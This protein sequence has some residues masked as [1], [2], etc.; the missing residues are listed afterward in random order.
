MPLKSANLSVQTT[1]LMATY[2]KAHVSGGAASVLVRGTSREIF[3][4]SS[5]LKS[6]SQ[7]SMFER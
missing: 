4:T 6:E 1:V 7:Q 3:G 2:G 5:P